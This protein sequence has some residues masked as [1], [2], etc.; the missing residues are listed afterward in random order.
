M[1]QAKVFRQHPCAKFFLALELEL[2]GSAKWA[3]SSFYSNSQNM[4]GTAHAAGAVLI[5]DN[6]EMSRGVHQVLYLLHTT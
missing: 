1:E 3:G 5:G 2:F 4:V 6:G